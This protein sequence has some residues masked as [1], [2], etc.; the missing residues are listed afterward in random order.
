MKET[1]PLKERIMR[2]MLKRHGEFISSGELQRL[3]SAYTTQ[4]PR[5]CVRRLQELHEDGQLERKLIK[6]HS[7]YR[8]VEQSPTISRSVG[9]MY[10]AKDWKENHKAMNEVWNAVT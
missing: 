4:T 5:T 6:G 9:V 2:Y 3:V 8:A 1:I 7:W 10:R